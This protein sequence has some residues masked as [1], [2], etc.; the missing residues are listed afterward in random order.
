MLEGERAV[1]VEQAASSRAV[2]MFTETGRRVPAHASG[3]GKA[4][5]AFLPAGELAELAGS[6]PWAATT[7]HTLTTMRELE[8]ELG[9]IRARGYAI[10]NEEYEEGVGC[11]GAPVFGHAGGL[12]AALSVSAPAA[13]LHRLGTHELGELLVA[14]D[15]GERKARR[16]RARR[17]GARALRRPGRVQR[18]A[19]PADAAL[20]DAGAAPGGR[21]GRRL[22]ARAGMTVRR[23]AVG[24]VIGRYEGAGP[25][26]T[27]LLGSHLDTVRD[28][29]RYDGHARG[30][31][32]AR[33][34]RAAARRRPR[35]CRSPI[36]VL[37]FA[38][39]EGVRYG[40]A[41]LGSGVAGRA[42]STR[43]PRPRAT[44]TAST[45][46]DALPRVRR[47]RR[48]AWRRR[49][50]TRRACSATARCTSS[51][52]R[53][54]RREG[55]PVG[56]VSAIAG[57]TRVGA[58]VRGRG[59]PRGHGA[60]GRCAATRSVAAAE[61]IVLAVEARGA[62]AA[63]GWWPRSASSPSEPGASNV[64]PGEAVLSLDV[65]HADDAARRAAPRAPARARRGDR[66]PRAGV[67]TDW[68]SCRRRRRWPAT[69]S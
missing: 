11:V 9:R 37:G 32:R 22:D 36:E 62:R 21:G 17:H 14:V 35:G 40:T 41:Y 33:V 60:D 50:A 43:L 55:L 5:L 10:D 39:E 57:Q 16:D 25:S 19:R 65:R 29:G 38:D 54:S 42:R 64:I 67:A 8:E 51:R 20:R 63:T 66:G 7:P 1:Y 61:W 47:R 34:R 56:V 18:G 26:A 68:S 58:D 52:G 15:D 53:C 69:R 23:D 46:A 48:A 4:M 27:L 12:V 44:P 30:A 28:A 24:N 31:R 13:R 6:E 59:R 2:R 49:A 3:A 45:M